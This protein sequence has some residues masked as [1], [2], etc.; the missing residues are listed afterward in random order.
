MGLLELTMMQF[1]G[2]PDLIIVMKTKRIRKTFKYFITA[3]VKS[4][5]NWDEL[6]KVPVYKLGFPTPQ[7]MTDFRFTLEDISA[8]WCIA[9]LDIYLS[10]AYNLGKKEQTMCTITQL[11]H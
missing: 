1:L 8:C 7:S 11:C 4:F 5:V 2:P 3:D 6:K 9:R 10:I